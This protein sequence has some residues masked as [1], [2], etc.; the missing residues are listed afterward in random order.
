MKSLEGTRLTLIVTGVFLLGD[1]RFPGAEPRPTGGPHRR[2]G[3]G[4]R[5][6][7]PPPSSEPRSA[8][9]APILP[10]AARHRPGG[11]TRDCD[12][13]SAGSPPWEDPA[14]GTAAK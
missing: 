12:A 2:L 7:K 9:G 6:R 5:V 1:L 3:R 13:G 10:A 8:P 11:A 4:S 14:C